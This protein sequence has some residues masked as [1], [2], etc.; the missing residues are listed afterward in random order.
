M[1]WRTGSAFCVAAMIWASESESDVV[2]ASAEKSGSGSISEYGRPATRS[3]SARAAAI[4]SSSVGSP[5]AC[6]VAAPAPPAR[7]FSA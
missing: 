1:E 6:A 7:Y 3:T 4:R 5:S 2:D